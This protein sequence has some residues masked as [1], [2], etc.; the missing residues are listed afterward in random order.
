MQLT[1]RQQP[2]FRVNSL[3]LPRRNRRV[4]LT[5]KQANIFTWG[6]QREARF[7]I[8]CCGRRFGKTFLLMEELRRA[9]RLAMEHGVDT[10]LEIWYSGVT[11]KQAEK[12]FWKRAIRSTPE[13]WIDKVNNSKHTITYNTGHVF[14]LVGLDNYDDLRG[15][16]L[17]FFMGDEWADTKPEAWTEVIEPMLSTCD[18]NAILIGTPKGY[19]HFY[20]WFVKGQPGA[21]GKF[22]TRSWR[23][24]TIEGGN[25]PPEEIEM[26]RRT[27]DPRAFRQEYEAS[28]ETYAGRIYYDFDRRESVKPCPFDPSRPVHVGM[29]FN[30]NPMTAVLYQERM[31]DGEVISEQFDEIIIPTSNTN[32]MADE[33]VRRFQ[34]LGWTADDFFNRVTVYPDPAGAGRRTASHGETDVTILRKYFSVYAMSSHPLV[35]DR[36]NVVNSRI[37]TADGRRHM[38]VDPSCQK[39]IEALEKHVYKEG[40]SEPEKGQFDHCTDAIGYYLFTRFAHQRAH[41][42]EMSPFMAT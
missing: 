28:F 6:F 15:S 17:F 16:G 11:L 27:N 42:V 14:R 38:Y 13:E 18:G 31:E 8:A 23:Y 2:Q 37:R 32:E 35:R 36:I 26:K 22:R 33:I 20:D 39:T 1:A 30:I 40:T 41:G 25:V 21:D 9:V 24:N 4:A 5:P 12:N 29:D 3:G 34:P 7:R 19:N 10:D